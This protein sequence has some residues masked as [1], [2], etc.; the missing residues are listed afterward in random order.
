M[1]TGKGL[2]KRIHNGEVCLGT[3]T[4]SADPCEVEILCGSGYDFVIVD[5]EHGALGIESV[6]RD[7][8]AGKGT[9]VAMIVR[10]PWNDP[11]LIKRALDTGPDGILAPW[12][13]TGEAAQQV[14]AACLY[15]PHGI[16]GWGPR[17]PSGYER[18][19]P[20]DYYAEAHENLVIWVQIE[21]LE[22]VNNADA[23]ARTPRLDGILI[24]CMDLSV[25]MG[26][27][28]QTRHP[29][30]V[31]AVDR[32]VAAGARAGVAVGL[33]GPADPNAA[34]AWLKKGLA[35]VTLGTATAMLMQA[36]DSAVAGVRALMHGTP[37]A[38]VRGSGEQS[39]R[40]G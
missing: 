16:R 40:V 31:E 17:R 34:F 11:V 21:T 28:G 6:Q 14:V 19:S 10:V 3:W 12:V 20:S 29:A 2:R 27:V 13:N 26:L 30:L 22:A 33:A 9:D 36:S 4:H 18:G 23:I 5:S 8:V 15:P 35:F 39:T 38:P 24:G 32:V 37:V 1:F 25:S 7:V